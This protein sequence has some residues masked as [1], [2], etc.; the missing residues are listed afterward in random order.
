MCSFLWSCYEN[1]STHFHI[2]LS[3][4]W[5]PR[6]GRSRSKGAGSRPTLKVSVPKFLKGW[7][8]RG[9]DFEYNSIDK[10]VSHND[11]IQWF[12]A[13]NTGI[14]GSKIPV[15]TFGPISRL[16][17]ETNYENSNFWNVWERNFYIKIPIELGEI[18]LE[19]FDSKHKFWGVE[20]GVLG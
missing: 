18:F 13:W 4:R 8:Y 5:N 19:F 11:I 14:F 1:L 10:S 2:L 7:F 15:L 17:R 9:Q 16:F 6:S 3:I 20:T 12:W